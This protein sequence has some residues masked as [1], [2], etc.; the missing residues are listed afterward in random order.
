MSETELM[1][2]VAMLTQD[3]INRYDSNLPTLE[4]I[5]SSVT[6]MMGDAGIDLRQGD[7]TYTQS[8]KAGAFTAISQDQGTKLEG[9]FTS[10]QNH[11]ANMDTALESVADKM[12]IA[13]GHLARIAENTGES[14]GHLK[15]IK[16][17]LDTIKRDGLKTR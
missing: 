4:N 2:Q 13:E 16:L 1:N 11:T 9:L 17:T 5:L 3:L 8:G 6:G 14:A 7:D 10:V 12:S 15:E